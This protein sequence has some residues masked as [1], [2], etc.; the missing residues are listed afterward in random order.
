[1]M[2]EVKK[3]LPVDLAICTAAVSDLKP[4]E[5]IKNKI[6]KDKINFKS[7]NFKKY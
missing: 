7:I 3:Y 6:K 5:K 2:N 4:I 1:M